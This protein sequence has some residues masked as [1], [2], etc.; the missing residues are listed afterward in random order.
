MPMISIIVT[1]YNIAEYLE[2]CIESIINQTY[3][4]IEI[5]LVDDGSDDGSAVICDRY[6]E[7]DSRIR[8]I[9]KTNGGLVS[10]RKAG[11]SAASGDY[12]MSVDGDDWI[13]SDWIENVANAIINE[14]LDMLCISGLCREKDGKSFPE[15]MNVL[16]GTFLG[17]EIE[18]HFLPQMVGEGD[19]F[20][21]RVHIG[22]SFVAVKT[23]LYL[24]IE[25]L[26]PNHFR[27][28]EEISAVL[29]LVD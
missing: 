29:L 6:G 16:E 28:G 7:I 14:D 11:A 10:A 3:K 19:Y 15:Q 26:I 9:H 23:S 2:K 8:V 17:K 27:Y 25:R 18:D 5:I 24:E 1:I 4:N 22:H 12:I 21:R 13:D 20:C